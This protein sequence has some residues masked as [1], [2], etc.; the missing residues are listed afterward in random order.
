MA[1]EHGFRGATLHGVNDVILKSGLSVDYE[2]VSRQA[3]LFRSV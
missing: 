1:K 3:E 2:M